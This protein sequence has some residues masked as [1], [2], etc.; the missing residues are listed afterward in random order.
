MRLCTEYIRVHWRS[1][2]PAVYQS[3]SEN[4]RTSSETACLHS[5]TSIHSEQMSSSNK[6]SEASASQTVHGCR[7][8]GSDKQQ[9]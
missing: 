7:E 6:A 3:T 9:T 5:A 4:L 2:G 1:R 8:E